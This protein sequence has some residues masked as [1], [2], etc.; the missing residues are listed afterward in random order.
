MTLFG[1]QYM[2]DTMISHMCLFSPAFMGHSLMQP[3]PKPNP[4]TYGPCVVL[5]NVILSSS[6]PHVS[7]L[8]FPNLPLSLRTPSAPLLCLSLSLCV[9]SPIDLDTLLLCFLLSFAIP[10]DE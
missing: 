10:V 6:P 3:F 9:Y 5:E 7:P 8:P 4:G 2:P 1:T